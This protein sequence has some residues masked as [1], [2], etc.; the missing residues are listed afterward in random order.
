MWKES[1][2]TFLIKTSRSTAFSRWTVYNDSFNKNPFLR[3][4]ERLASSIRNFSLAVQT[5]GVIRSKF[6][7]CRSNV[8]PH[9]FEIIPMA[10]KYLQHPFEFFFFCDRSNGI[11]NHFKRLS[12][13]SV[14][15]PFI[16]LW[17]AARFDRLTWRISVVSF[18][19]GEVTNSKKNDKWNHY[20]INFIRFWGMTPTWAHV[21]LYLY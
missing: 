8:L 1:K 21:K 2:H 4:S 10:F 12:G 20:H 7:H 3:S 16:G 5:A 6:S 18:F 11:W 15:H 19:A 13:T 14:S 17:L 9:L